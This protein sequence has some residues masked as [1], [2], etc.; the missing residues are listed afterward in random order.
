MAIG[1]HVVNVG[2]LKVDAVGNVIPK[3]NATTPIS[4]HLS[5]GHEHRVLPDAAIPNSADYP[6]VKTYLEAEAA[7]NYILNHMD[8]TTIITYSAADINDA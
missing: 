8:Q 3:G 4:A 5:S 1:I 7:D 2:F 6:T